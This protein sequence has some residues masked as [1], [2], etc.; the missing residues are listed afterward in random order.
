[1]Q[2]FTPFPFVVRKIGINDYE[3]VDPVNEI[4]EQAIKD[5]TPNL[6]TMEMLYV[7]L[8]KLFPLIAVK[9]QHN[10]NFEAE[11]EEFRRWVEQALRDCPPK[12]KSLFFTYGEDELR[13]EEDLRTYSISLLGAESYDA[14]GEWKY[15]AKSFTKSEFQSES[16]DTFFRFN[17]QLSDSLLDKEKKDSF[18]QVL[19]KAAF[20]SDI[21]LYGYCSLLIVEALRDTIDKQLFGRNIFFGVFVDNELISDRSLELTSLVN[22][23]R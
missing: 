17:N 11:S 7:E 15:D 13:G 1:M 20:L 3:L 21:I 4:L 14:D 6:M 5:R 18:Y 8:S 16:L 19:G 12:T 10:L 9:P 2:E 22:I 23:K